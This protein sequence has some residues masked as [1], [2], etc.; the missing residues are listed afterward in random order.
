MKQAT[1]ELVIC[2]TSIIAC[3]VYG[4]QICYKEYVASLKGSAYKNNVM[5]TDLP[6]K[7]ILFLYW[8]GY[9]CTIKTF[10]HIFIFLWGSWDAV[11]CIGINYLFPLSLYQLTKPSPHPLIPNRMGLC[12]GQMLIETATY[13]Y[14]T[15]LGASR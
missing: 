11:S 4:C 13:S 2:R 6:K 7:I 3:I 5:K 9:G 8:I 15:R 12:H 10:K 1:I 14:H